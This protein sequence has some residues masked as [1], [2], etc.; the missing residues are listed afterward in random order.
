MIPIVIDSPGETGHMS[1]FHSPMPNAALHTVTG[2]P[3]PEQT[4]F[5]DP[6]LDRA[7]GV[8]MALATEVFVLRDRL[9]AVETQ[10]AA[11]GAL[12]RDALAREPSPQELAESTDD[13]R[14]FVADLLTSLRGEQVSRGAS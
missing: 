10:L 13:R 14:R 11:R 2:T 5:A 6:A 1:E 9:N 7:F 8:V 12:D 4:F 3:R